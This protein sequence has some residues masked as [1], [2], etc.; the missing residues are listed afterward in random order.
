MIDKPYAVLDAPSNLGLREPSPGAEPGCCRFPE[1]LRGTGFV[2]RIGASDAGRA[3]PPPY[4]YDWNGKT[5][6]NAEGIATYSVQ[7]A[8][9]VGE[10]LD[11]DTFPVVIGGDCSILLGNTLALRRRGRYGLV[12]LDGHLD[13]RHPGNSPATGAAAGEDFALVTGRGQDDL[14]NLEGHRPYVRDEDAISIGDTDEIEDSADIF[15]TGLAVINY[16]EFAQRGPVDT[17]KAALQRVDRPELDGFWIHLD[18]DILD[19]ELMPAVDSTHSG[20]LTWDEL[21]YLLKGLLDEP[22]A[23]GLEVTIFDPDLDPDNI[24]ITALADCLVTALQR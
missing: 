17:L 6:F 24:Y 14:T 7:L 9:R 13:F 10:L 1:A 8:D 11:S 16:A 12:H 22:K 5:V 4:A 19:S 3:E 20:G 2:Q 21:D 23:T 15:K 18:V